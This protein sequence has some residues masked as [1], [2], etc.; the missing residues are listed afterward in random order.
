MLMDVK[1]FTAELENVMIELYNR[2]LSTESAI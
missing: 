1:G 2:I